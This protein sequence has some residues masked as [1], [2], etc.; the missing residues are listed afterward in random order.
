M[1]SDRD[2]LVSIIVP[3]YNVERYLDQCL[4][5]IEAQTYKN[6]EIICINDGSTDNSLSIIEKHA[7]ADPRYRVIDKEN[8]GYGVGCNLGISEATGTWIS[9]VEPDDWL[10]PHMYEDMLAFAGTFE[11]RLDV[12]KTPWWNY[13]DWPAPKKP[14]AASA[15]SVAASRPRSAPLPS[16]STRCSSR[17][18][19][20]Y[21]RR[22]T[23]RA[24]STSTGSV[25]QSTPAR[26]GPITPSW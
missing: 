9:I 1:Y 7:A 21:G 10:D 25:S 12:I 15:S 24:S 16:R 8:G 18:T 23:A 19:R 20:E 22:S 13:E 11:E 17:S 3:I 26:V 5:S 14:S 2:A 4:D 6:L